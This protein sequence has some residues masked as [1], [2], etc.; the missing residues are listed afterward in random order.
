MILLD[1]LEKLPEL[2]KI[3]W[4]ELQTNISP[5]QGQEFFDQAYLRLKTENYYKNCLSRVTTLRESLDRTS[6]NNLLTLSE[7]CKKAYNG[8]IYLLGDSKNM[9]AC[10]QTRFAALT[11]KMRTQWQSINNIFS[12]AQGHYAHNLCACQVQTPLTN[13]SLRHGPSIPIPSSI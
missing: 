12:R 2:E 5:Y 8:C 13:I 9:A 4:K 1:K 3:C 7:K 6:D 11:G 10:S